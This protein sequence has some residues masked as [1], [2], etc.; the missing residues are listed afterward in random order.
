MLGG[1]GDN[2]VTKAF[3]QLAYAADYA[4]LAIMKLGAAAKQ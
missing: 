3:F 2:T 1:W 4:T